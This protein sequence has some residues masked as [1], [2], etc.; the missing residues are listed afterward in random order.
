ML[1]DEFG[2]PLDREAYL[3]AWKAYWEILTAAERESL[4][5]DVLGEAGD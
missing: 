5:L 2:N 1:W 4:W 3:E